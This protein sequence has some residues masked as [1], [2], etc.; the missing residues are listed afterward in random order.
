MPEFDSI[1]LM[2][3]AVY[4][5]EQDPE[6][7][8]I[9]NYI[10]S[11]A[12]AQRELEELRRSTPQHDRKRRDLSRSQERGKF[13]ESESSSDPRNANS[14]EEKKKWWSIFTGE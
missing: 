5:N 9:R 10:K 4:G 2:N 3:Y 1:D 13:H 12:S 7:A 8:D 6:W 11:S 14:L